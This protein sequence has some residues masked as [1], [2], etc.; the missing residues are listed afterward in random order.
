MKRFDVVVLGGGW[1]GYTAAV[2]A[3]ELGLA[4]ALVERDKLGGTCLHR[5]CIP[6]KVL[7]QSAETLD[8]ARRM[9]ELGVRVAGEPSL[10]YVAVVERKRQVVERLYTGLQQ[11]VRTS[12][13][14]VIAGNGRLRGAGNVV[15]DGGS[16]GGELTAANII[17]ATGSRPK[18]LPG[19]ETDGRWIMDSDQALELDHVPASVIVLGGGAVG[20]E[21]A[22]FYRDAGAEVTV[23]EMLPALLPLEDHEI[24]A[25]LGRLFSRRGIRVLTG[26]AASLTSI[27]RTE[28]GVSLN[29]STAQGAEQLAAECLLVAVG[30]EPLSADLGLEEAGV[31]VDKGFIAVD[32][33]MHTSAA[34]V[35]AAG[36]VIGGLLLAHVAAAEGAHAAEVIAG[37]PSVPVESVRLPRATY[38]RPQVASVGLTEHEA[39]EAGRRVRVGRAR[40]GANGK[41]VI[42]GEPEG[43]VKVVADA[44]ND[45]LLGLHLIGPGVTELIAAG[46]L[47]RLLDA[48]LWE[49]AVNVYPHPTLSEAIGDAARSAARPHRALSM[50]T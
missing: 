38:C 13:V 14:Q 6:S 39:V 36:D 12:G 35:Y 4:V 50:E 45:D 11:L 25:M 20:C 24:S 43:M 7:L 5:G 41:A 37:V 44:G 49:L 48:G 29:V 40:L 22:S 21:F 28:D 17:L 47:A 19:V 1:G 18:P 2:R 23:V 34:G 31:R 32:A 3:R 10:D 8:L 9:A 16:Q 42:L 30:R 27:S 26:A 15:V 46:A 33:E